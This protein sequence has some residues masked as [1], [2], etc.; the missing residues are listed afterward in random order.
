MA[1]LTP[2]QCAVS[3]DFADITSAVSAPTGSE[4]VSVPRWAKSATVGWYKHSGSATIPI[5]MYGKWRIT[6]AW[7]TIPFLSTANLD[8][9]TN[10]EI[11]WEF[12][13]QL[14][15]RI[16][17]DSLGFSGTATAKGIITFLRR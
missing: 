12:N 5:V 17:F 3:K 4:G 16:A 6:D 11:D 2:E 13:P 7:R 9:E 10:D 8:A 1:L 15:S 14:Y